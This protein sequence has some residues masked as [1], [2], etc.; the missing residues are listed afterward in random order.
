MKPSNAVRRWQYMPLA[1][2]IAGL[3]AFQ[4]S[5]PI[6]LAQDD[7]GTTTQKTGDDAK[8]LFTN[9]LHNAVLGKFA[10]ADAFAKSLLAKNPDPL[11]I[12]KWADEHTNS[13]KTL[14]LLL[15]KIEVSESASQVMDLIR[16]GELLMR[17]DPQ[18]I[19]ANIQKLG[20]EP[21][22]EFN[23]TNR[24]RDSG[25]YAVPWLVSTLQDD[26]QSRLHSRII[27]MLPKMGKSAVNPLVIALKM[28]DNETKQFLVKALGQIGYPQAI[29]HLLAV[30][31]NPTSSREL[32]STV[33][34]AISNI[35]SSSPS[36]PSIAPGEA[37]LDL[38]K[39]YYADHGS[40]K[41]DPRVDFAN[42][43]YWRDGRLQRTEVPREIFNEI[44]AMRCS[45]E[46]LRLQPNQAEAVAIWLGAN[47]RREAELSM[48]VESVEPD[49]IGLADLTK[50]ENF[51]RSAY[52]AR[53]AG[54]RYCHMVL[55]MAVRDRE[56]A[57]A[58]GAIA[59]LRLIAGEA[60]LV[61]PGAAMEPLAQALNFPDQVVRIKAALA[62][63]HA[64]PSTSFVGSDR[65]V[66]TL[67]EALSQTGGQYCLVIEPN[68]ANRNRVM[69][70]LRADQTIAIGEGD[71]YAALQ[72]AR[73]ELPTVSAIVLAA[74]QDVSA[75][76]AAIRANHL[77]AMTP[78]VL[79]TNEDQL[80]VVEMLVK[81]DP[82][83]AFV[84]A[85]AS[86]EQIRQAWRRAARTVGQTSLMADDA[87]VLALDATSALG[88]IAMSH[89][90][91]YDANVAEGGLTRALAGD[92]ESLQ[93]AAASV[94]ALLSS[95][96]AQQSIAKVA[97][98]DGNTES[99]RVAAFDSLAA[100]AKVNANL[101]TEP[102]IN[103]LVEMSINDPNLIIRS[104]AS[105]SL[106]ALNLPTNKVV[107]IIDKYY[108]G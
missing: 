72:R 35:I 19:K 82:A 70:A 17:R 93:I 3:T 11:D 76:V 9:F 40:V 88:K 8:S 2:A 64:L 63:A 56:S 90:P 107:P 32:R 46:A 21:Q 58:L 43:W 44:M 85:Q 101:L 71:L 12:L 60:S 92:D 15:S 50:A 104:A 78:I 66:P 91:V 5:L 62:L 4:A 33:E 94:L 10:R 102:Q 25:E 67:A 49:E 20:G 86:S 97:L 108:R 36:L 45:E 51:P 54:A 106:G 98:G 61:G 13:I 96:T 103:R 77:Y 57:V 95:P 31:E 79:L 87:L 29:P 6:S 55:D 14:D 52:F 59:A 18:R 7:A 75:T 105:Q 41:A 83:A 26:T 1:I 73:Q 24:L 74:D 65:V 84:T 37:F 38:A 28:D 23:A 99:L 30:L 27:R 39:Q 22:M 16:E 89:S 42:V 100:S 80:G 81:S 34:N 48:D 68:E 47:I 53:A 69:D